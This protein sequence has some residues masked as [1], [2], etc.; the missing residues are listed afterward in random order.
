[1]LRRSTCNVYLAIKNLRGRLFCGFDVGIS[2]LYTFKL[3]LKLRAQLELDI[4][5]FF[6]NVKVI[7]LRIRIRLLMILKAT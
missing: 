4:K 7:E 2:K 1:M 3:H 6:K 5:L